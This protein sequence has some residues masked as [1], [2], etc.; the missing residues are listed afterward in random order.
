MSIICVSYAASTIK[1]QTNITRSYLITTDLIHIHTYNLATK[2]NKRAYHTIYSVHHS[3]ACQSLP[4][5]HSHLKWQ[6][7]TFWIGFAAYA[8]GFWFWSAYAKTWVIVV[9]FGFVAYRLS[10]NINHWVNSVPLN[11]K[12]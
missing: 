7:T 10:V 12:L 8:V 6:I 2:Q 5:Y 1:K 9:A 4:P 3:M 11:R